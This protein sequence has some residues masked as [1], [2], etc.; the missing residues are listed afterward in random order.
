MGDD[1]HCT[2]LVPVV[3]DKFQDE[4]YCESNNDMVERAPVKVSEAEDTKNCVRIPK[5]E[6]TQFVTKQDL[7]Q[8]LSMVK[9]KNNERLLESQDLASAS[10]LGSANT[11]NEGAQDQTLSEDV[12]SLLYVAPFKSLAFAYAAFV[13]CFQWVLVSL[14]LYD[15]LAPGAANPLQIPSGVPIQVTIAQVFALVLA[16]AM[17]DDLLE[18]FMMHEWARIILKDDNLLPGTTATKCY[19]S[20][21]AQCLEGSAMLTVIFILVMQSST[22]I[23]MFLNFAALQF[24]WCIDNV[25]FTLAKNGFITA[26]VQEACEVVDNLKIPE[27]HRSKNWFK[28]L[29]FLFVCTG[30]LTGYGIIVHWQHSGKYICQ[31]LVLQFGDSFN[32]LMSAFSGVYERTDDHVASRATYLETRG[33]RSRIA[34]CEKEKAWTWSH[35]GDISWLP[36]FV[37]NVQEKNSDPC[38]NWKARSEETDSF[39]ITTTKAW[40][41]KN[42]WSDR[43]QLFDH[44][45]LACNDCGED[46]CNSKHG[47]CEGNK[48]LCKP[49]YF[50]LNCEFEEPCAE[51]SVDARQKPF[52]TFEGTNYWEMKPSMDVLKDEEGNVVEV[53]HKPVYV[54]EYSN[55]T[56]D[57]WD[58]LDVMLFNGRR[59]IITD[60]DQMKEL[61]AMLY[62][63]GGTD[64]R[65]A[66]V[67]YLSNTFHAFHSLP[68]SSFFVSGGIDMGT[69]SDALTPIGL[70]WYESRHR[71]GRL[72]ELVLGFRYPESNRGDLGSDN[73]MGSFNMAFFD[74][75]QAISVDTALICGV[76]DEK[77]SCLNRQECNA[78]VCS[79]APSYDGKLCEVESP[80]S[81]SRHNDSV[82]D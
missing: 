78:G 10:T 6:L 56:G 17:Q 62:F 36:S 54:A 38:S 42:P 81:L 3:N 76:C 67:G 28:R 21:V 72:Y 64:V 19:L 16:A 24:V 35:E 4:D 44:F 50:G 31:S 58:G 80:T 69:P 20:V 15:L 29:V 66:L 23:G 65:S 5:E 32:P 14:A 71:S 73:D 26:G 11:T 43:V 75:E 30:L 68:Y 9:N 52:P 45:F 22:I 48:C 77:N 1:E 63:G 12:Y 49:G 55:G 53:Y 37:G 82:S 60:T 74:P 41:V 57:S 18:G 13:V 7:E 47:Y 2:A 59:Y 25:G 70:Q 27:G 34:Y 33:R 8:V 51:V 40:F 39:D 61:Q 79:C 46:I